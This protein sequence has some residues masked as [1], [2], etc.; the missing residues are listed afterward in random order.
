[1]KL[2]YHPNGFRSLTIIAFVL[3]LSIGGANQMFVAQPDEKLDDQADEIGNA[4]L[5]RQLLKLALDILDVDG[6]LGGGRLL[7]PTRYVAMAFRTGKAFLFAAE[8]YH[9]ARGKVATASST[10]FQ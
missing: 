2:Q 8:N 4:A 5:G 7:H 10:V 9:S 3:A 6:K 1:M